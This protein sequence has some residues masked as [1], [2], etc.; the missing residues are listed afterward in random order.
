MLDVLDFL[1]LKQTFDTAL[2]RN[3]S[4]GDRFRCI[5]DDAWWIGEIMSVEPADENFPD[6]YFMCFR[7][8]WDNGEMEKMSPWDLEPIDENSELRN[9][10][11]IF[12]INFLYFQK[13]ECEFGRE[14]NH[15]QNFEKCF[16]LKNFFLCKFY[17]II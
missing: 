11:I 1:V 7:V 9:L 16:F 3:W 12:R 13:T 17:L 14:K 10:I 15:F 2:N 6:S 8:R 5:I 4:E